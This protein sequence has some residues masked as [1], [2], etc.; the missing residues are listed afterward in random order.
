MMVT[1]EITVTMK[2][3]KCG[4]VVK[5]MQGSEEIGTKTCRFC[6]GE[7]KKTNTE[8]RVIIK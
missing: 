6:G 8:R 4:V 7:L 1:E 2:C 3:E 5:I